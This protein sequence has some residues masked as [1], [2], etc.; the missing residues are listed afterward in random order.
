MHSISTNIL[1]IYLAHNSIF[2]KNIGFNCGNTSLYPNSSPFAR[3]IERCIST[4]FD[5]NTNLV[6]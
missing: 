3:E 1:M 4:D 2:L 6:I 5:L